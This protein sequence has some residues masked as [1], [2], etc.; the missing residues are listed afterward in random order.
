LVP[1]I[2][3]CGSVNQVHKTG[4]T[5]ASSSLQKIKAA[6]VAPLDKFHMH[7]PTHHPKRAEDLPAHLLQ[8]LLVFTSARKRA[9][10]GNA[11]FVKHIQRWTSVLLG[12]G[13]HYL[14]INHQRIDMIHFAGNVALQQV[15]RLPVTEHVQA[16]PKLLL[17]IDLRYT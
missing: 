7:C 5:H 14:V 1:E 15:E 10:C 16:R 17:A 3:A 6:I 8:G 9:R 4:A 11:S 2:D 12:L 13:K